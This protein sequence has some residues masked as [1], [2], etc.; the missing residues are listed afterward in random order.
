MVHSEVM[1]EDKSNNHSRQLAI[2]V[3]G[4]LGVVYGDIGTSPL[5]TIREC[6]HGLSKIESSPANVLGILSLVTWALIIVISVKYVTFV[7]RA[8]NNGEGGMLALMTLALSGMGPAPSRKKYLVLVLGLFGTSLLYGDGMITPSISVLS[9]V[10]GLKR[11]TPLFE[12]Y[13][14]PLTIVI[15]VLLFTFQSRGTAQIG[16]VFGPVI[17]LWFITIGTLGA[18]SIIKMPSV[19][20]ALN[21]Y[22]ALRF[23]LS[24]GSMGFFVLGAVFLATT[25]GEA[26][27]ADM[28]HFG[29]RAIQV[30][31]YGVA[32]PALLLN[33][34][35]QG[36]IILR[37]PDAVVNPFYALAPHWGIIPLV[38]ISTA[39][40]IVASQALIS[41][42]FSLTRQ[43]VLLGYLPRIPIIHTSKLQIGQIYV[44]VTNVVLMLATVVLVLVFQNSTG[45]AAAYGVGVTSDMLITTLLWCVV[46]R[47][48][49]GWPRWIT[50]LIVAAFLVFDIGFFSSALTKIPHGGWVPLAVG[51]FMLTLMTTWRKGRQILGERLYN[52]TLPLKDFV[53]NV[54]PAE[55]H[56]TRVPG[57]AIFLSGNPMVT[58][59]VLLHNLKYNKVLHETTA[60]M[61]VVIKEVPHVPVNER[62]SLE[63]LGHGFH[64]I[65]ARYGFMESPNVHEIL[66]LCKTEGL[67]IDE[68]TVGFFIGR[69]NIIIT[70]N[71]GMSKFRQRLF[72]FMARNAQGATS[73]FGIP[74]N[75]VVELGVQVQL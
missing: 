14:V 36:S 10:E 8:D 6:F 75:Q 59:P 45:F 7:L 5:Y 9:A 47:G 43:A 41:G 11:A 69:E 65:T 33:Y 34:Y 64:R 3:L 4:A 21:P 66:R 71:P 46:A 1:T 73:F 57:A 15:L 54:I 12:P 25:G 13:V 24:N 17:L 58:P 30:G 68:R 27:Y 51:L 53:Q 56:L 40:T 60:V 42:A 32:L 61:N 52:R 72:A 39:A 18:L 2:L 20:M 48:T 16:A 19:L 35:G 63:S 62:L 38:I 67:K 28:G 23:F 22:Y 74:P 44:P 29:R 37:S 55:T 31:W 50:G 49:W 26:L 70:A